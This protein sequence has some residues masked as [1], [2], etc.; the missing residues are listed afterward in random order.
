MNLK[1]SRCLPSVALLLV[2]FP[3]QLPL[4]AQSVPCSAIT[5]NPLL[6]EALL[7]SHSQDTDSDFQDDTINA[8]QLEHL[9]F[10][11]IVIQP[12]DALYLE[13]RGREFSVD[14]DFASGERTAFD[15]S[16]KGSYEQWRK[17][18]LPL[19]MFREALSQRLVRLR[20]TAK[21]PNQVLFRNVKIIRAGKPIF[22]FASLA[23]Y[24]KPQVRRTVER[25]LPCVAFGDVPAHGNPT[26]VNYSNPASF[27]NFSGGL[28][29]PMLPPFSMLTM[30]SI[31]PAGDPNH[32]KFQGK[33]S[34]DESG[35]YNFGAR[36]HSPALGRYIS[37][38]WFA[39]PT[40]VPYA[41]F[42]NPQTLNLYSFGR[43]DPISVNDP[44]GHDPGDKFKSKTAAAADA[45]RYIRK[46]ENGYKWE[47]GT[48]IEKDGKIYTYKEPV[49]QKNPTGVDLPSLQKNDVG[50]VHTHNY[51]VGQDVHANSI[52]QPDRIGTVQDKEQ[53]QKMQGDPK[54]TVDYQS[55]VGAPNGDLIQ[56][57]PNPNAPDGLGDAKVVQHNV[58]PD[59]NPPHPPVQQPAA[60]PK[61]EEPK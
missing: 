29:Q 32:Y 38:D 58:S 42:T 37:P 3:V 20:A 59:A 27:R 31:A 22:E 30:Q 15:S 48:R 28:V 46:Q 5:R 54:A 41:D 33:E 35:L 13:Y 7:D 49:T 43:N 47:Y 19:D 9:Q 4:D 16:P 52:E 40:T 10:S 6:L 11:P 56:F 36:Y 21:S 8:A 17:G 45:V 39:R 14:A 2:V 55:Y 60:Q 25:Q 26:A 51:G 53:V 1:V 18:N 12:G 57:T 50:D 34:D 44:D 61:K 24:G 23:S